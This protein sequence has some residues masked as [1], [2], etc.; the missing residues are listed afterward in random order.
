M[1][2][3]TT[4]TPDQQAL[5]KD[6]QAALAD[7]RRKL[8]RIAL[9]SGLIMGVGFATV[10]GVIGYRM[11]NRGEPATAI[12]SLPQYLPIPP[13]TRVLAASLHDDR[14]ALTL[15]KDGRQSVFVIDL[16]TGGEIGHI[17][18]TPTPPREND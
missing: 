14:L 10:F 9:V 13:G 16:E 3:N 8:S 1:T 4:S 7:I 2:E 17:R 5:S 15:E 12:P 11:M 18:L 6:D